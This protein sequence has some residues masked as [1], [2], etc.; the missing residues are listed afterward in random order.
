[1]KEDVSKHMKSYG[2]E[3]PKSKIE[4][5]ALPWLM[6]CCDKNTSCSCILEG[7]QS[8]KQKHRSYWSQFY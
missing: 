4:S 1:M 3:P 2:N 6:P 8:R 5:L 7:D